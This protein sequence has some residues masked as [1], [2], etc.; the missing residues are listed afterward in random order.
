ME[1]EACSAEGIPCLGSVPRVL[2]FT[3]RVG[4]PMVAVDGRLREGGTQREEEPDSSKRN[5][6]KL[7]GGGVQGRTTGCA[8]AQRHGEG[9]AF[10][11][12]RIVLCAV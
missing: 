3:G 11:E 10:E 8:K 7:P 12:V 4:E 5:Q 1:G 6:G 2:A 9:R